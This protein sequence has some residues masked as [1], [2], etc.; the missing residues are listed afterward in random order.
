MAEW[1]SEQ[2]ELEKEAENEMP[3]LVFKYNE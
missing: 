1:I 2:E 3:G